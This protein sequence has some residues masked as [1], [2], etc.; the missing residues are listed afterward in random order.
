MTDHEALLNDLRPGKMVRLTG[1]GIL[2]RQQGGSLLYKHDDHEREVSKQDALTIL[3]DHDVVIF[4]YWL[5]DILALF[6]YLVGDPD[7][8][9]CMSYQHV[10]QHGAAA[11]EAMLDESR[12][13]TRDEYAD[14]QSELESMGYELAIVEDID[15]KQALA[16]RRRQLQELSL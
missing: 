6:P 16:S 4:R 1:S 8:S 15:R 12:P 9:T 5:E 13:A 7:P 3:T 11:F 14:L 2:E 10:G